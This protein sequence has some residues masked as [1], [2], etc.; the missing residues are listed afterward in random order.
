M[1][2]SGSK[3]LEVADTGSYLWGTDYDLTFRV[4]KGA[5]GDQ[6]Q[7]AKD[8]W[9]TGSGDRCLDGDISAVL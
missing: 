1:V 5:T 9:D 2:V 7:G 8:P 6:H 3:S 4:F